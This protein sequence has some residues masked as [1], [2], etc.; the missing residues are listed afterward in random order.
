MKEPMDKAAEQ[1]V[2]AGMINNKD[3]L[4]DGLSL[5]DVDFFTEDATIKIF[6][7]VRDSSN[8]GIT[9]AKMLMKEFEDP[10]EK[11]LIRHIDGAYVDYDHFKR[12]LDDLKDTYIKRQLYFT[13][14]KALSLINNQESKSDEI[15]ST[16]E[17]DI[18]TF[19]FEDTDENIINP[20]ERAAD[21]YTEF[22]AKVDNP[23]LAK[24]IP[25]SVIN[26]RGV[27]VGFPSLDE[28][29]NGAQGGDLIMLAAKTGEGKTAFA[30]NVARTFS[31]L[32]NYWGYYQNTEMKVPEMES[33]LLAPIAR[34]PAK[35]L[36]YGRVDGNDTALMNRISN[37]YDVYR[38]SKLFLSRIPS[39]PLHKSK[40]L[41]RQFKNRFK[42]LDYMIIDY[43]GR[44]DLSNKE[45]NMQHWDVMYEIVKQLKELAMELNIPIFILAQRNQAGEVE[46]A[47]KMMNE[48]DG[49]L[50]FEPIG[51]NDKEHIER[52]FL[53][54][55]KQQAINYKITKK[56]VRR[57]D[58]PYPIYCNFDKG[59]QFINEVSTS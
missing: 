6:Q 24:G 58:N 3:C 45:R 16:V 36:Y 52:T 30:V 7:K 35:D 26:E 31:L 20:A 1:A 23:E 56:K 34:V 27:R 21:G 33:R 38:K 42:R 51:E 11:A 44:M 39:L 10:K 5:L 25:F 53:N 17:R 40:G 13:M 2:L 48:C 4:Y 46:G 12:N 49:V 22:L 29:F 19:F 57:D 41:A 55:D 15:I 14:N 9:T 43:I 28:V 50:F 32:Q 37:A 59:K 8:K 54:P 18:G 47:K